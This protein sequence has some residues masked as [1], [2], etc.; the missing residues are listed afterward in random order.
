MG[1]AA[2]LVSLTL[3][4]CALSCIMMAAEYLLPSGPLKSSV[5]V[6]SGIL[7]L[8]AVIEQITGIFAG[9]GV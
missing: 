3:T 1:I 4:I 6:G 9:N 5:S 7:L 8:C 2:S